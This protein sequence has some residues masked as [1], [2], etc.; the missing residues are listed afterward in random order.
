MDY[1]PPGS[2]V[3]R[4]DQERILESAAMPPLGDLSH[5]EVKPASLMSS[6]L[7][8][9]FFTTNG[10]WKAS[11]LVYVL[12]TLEIGK[13]SLIGNLVIKIQN[14]FLSEFIF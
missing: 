8:V 9:G 10:V 12:L 7:T 6:V 11:T 5:P 2:C 14:I 4:I 13:S 3:Q 1:S